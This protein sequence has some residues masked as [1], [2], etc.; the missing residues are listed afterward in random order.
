[1]TEAEWL[2]AEDPDPML[3]YLRA[4]RGRAGERKLRLLACACCRRVWDLLS[5]PRSR[6]AVETG[7]RYVDGRA[8]ERDMA[9]ARAEAMT[10]LKETASQAAWAAYW[11]V[12]RRASESVWHA[13]AAAAG[14][15][16][17]AAGRAAEAGGTDQ[18][19]AWHAARSAVAR[20]QAGLVR[21]VFGNPFRPP[22]VDPAWLK[23]AGGTVASLARAAYQERSF[24]R[25]PVLADALEE[26]GCADEVILSHCRQPG[27]HV[28]GCW[29]VDRLLGLE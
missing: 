8:G 26:A 25:M 28:R 18:A 21:E 16:L 9:A 5:D 1:M 29:V 19:A 24:D 20:D 27:E 4:E 12:N 14:A 7:E 6:E 22:A 17:T 2:A 10:A 15:V 11:A 23:W 3:A 13:C